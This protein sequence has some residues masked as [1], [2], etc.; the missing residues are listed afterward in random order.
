MRLL[1][2]D[3]RGGEVLDPEV[4]FLSLDTDEQLNHSSEITAVI[5]AEYNAE[6]DARGY[7]VILERGT[8]F[9]AEF[10]DGRLLPALVETAPLT[11]VIDVQA[12]GPS[13]LSKDAPWAGA[14]QA[15]RGYDAANAWRFIW[16]HIAG[17]SRLPRLE[18]V[19]NGKQSGVLVG[20]DGT[21]MWKRVTA[22]IEDAQRFLDRR[23]NR[24]DYWGRVVTSRLADLA[25]AARRKSIGEVSSS[26]DAPTT[27]DGR[28]N[29]IHIRLNENGNINSTYFWRWT[30][31]GSGAWDRDTTTAT[32]TATQRYLAAQASLE[33]A[34]NLYP[35]YERRVADLSAWLEEHYPDAGPEAYELNWW[36]TRDL[37]TNLEEIR[38]LGGLS[39]WETA[40]WDEQ[41]RII[42]RIHLTT[43]PVGRTREDL[44]FE[45][46]VNV[47][48][49]PELVRGDVATDVTVLG[50]GEG[51]ATL[52]AE[53][54]WNHPRLVRTP[55][56]LS[57]SD[58]GTRQLVERAA[59]RALE[60]ARAALD[61]TITSLEVTD[62]SAA[63]LDDLRLRDV[64][65]LRGR[66]QDGTDISYRLRITG[67]SRSWDSTGAGDQA[68][69]TVEVI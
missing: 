56:T 50:T 11:D 22:Q 23:D 28:T 51:D 4:P 8:L 42:P 46:G 26:N 37:S 61:Y 15:W 31:V 52:A 19:W 29:G 39:W 36:S 25:K 30:G 64:I 12:L 1:A 60:E 48:D 33:R 38:E 13:A 16:N 18:I 10:D 7:P 5:P 41:H 44:W 54:G 68:T 63:R 65:T 49:L 53:R 45:I 9:V 67:I 3:A 43:E 24:V 20:R 40:A 14:T 34:E 66:I 17:R 69:L 59:D 55:R 2:I 6:R 47:H 21:A 35:T 57:E 32:R 27:S 58:L 62:S